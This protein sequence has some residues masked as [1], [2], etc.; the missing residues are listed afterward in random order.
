MCDTSLSSS[1]MGVAAFAVAADFRVRCSVEASP[2]ELSQG[3]NSADR[4]LI[5]SSGVFSSSWNRRSRAD[6][7]TPASSNGSKRTP[8][9][10]MCPKSWASERAQASCAKGCS[11]VSRMYSMTPRDQ[12]SHLAPYGQ[13]VSITSGAR[14]KRVPHT[15]VSQCSSVFLGHRTAARPKSM[16]L[17]TRRCPGTWWIMQFSNFRSRWITPSSWQY[18]IAVKAS[19]NSSWSSSVST[20]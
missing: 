20:E 11:S 6:W 5:R 9:C 13:L 7:H 14:K 16:T 19:R 18:A 4:A 2:P 1:L 3:W 10:T 17:P 8:P 12:Q 15:S